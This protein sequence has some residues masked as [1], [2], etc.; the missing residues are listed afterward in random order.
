MS[1]AGTA[2]RTR[3]LLDSAA[4]PDSAAEPGTIVPPPPGPSSSDQFLTALST[5]HFTLQGARASTISEAGARSSLFMST[6]SS[7]VVALALIGTV[8]EVGPVF[9]LFALA[10]LPVLFA[11]GVLTYLRLSENAIEDAFY[12]RAINRIRRY[13]AVIDPSRAAYLAGSTHDDLPGVMASAG[14]PLSAW[15]LL[16]HTATM[17]LVV[18]AM[19]AGAGSSLVLHAVAPA[20]LNLAAAL[21]GVVFVAVNVGLFRHEVLSWRRAAAEHATLFPGEGPAS[22][23]SDDWIG[24]HADGGDSAPAPTS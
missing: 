7:G 21:G 12:G 20:E 1:A 16:S 15:H 4:P 2:T 14:H 18:T 10:L 8:S 19:I 24:D 6:V 11:L 17:V 23:D 22:R 3:P 5:E 13:Y 9:N